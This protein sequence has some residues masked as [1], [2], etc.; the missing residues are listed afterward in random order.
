MNRASRDCEHRNSS[1]FV[2][3]ICLTII[4]LISGG[5]VDNIQKSL[6]LGKDNNDNNLSL[7]VEKTNDCYH[8]FNHY[9][10]P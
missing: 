2:C 1:G 4:G 7:N 6:L 9:P 8:N 10:S 3:L 5:S